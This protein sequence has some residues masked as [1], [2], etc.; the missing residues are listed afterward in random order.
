VPSWPGGLL[1]LASTLLLLATAKAEE[2][3]NIRYFGPAYSEYMKRT[4]MFIPFLF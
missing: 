4:K 1:A 3:E 2:S